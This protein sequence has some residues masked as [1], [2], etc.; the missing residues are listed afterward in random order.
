MYDGFPNSFRDFKGIGQWRLSHRLQQEGEASLPTRRS[1]SLEGVTRA[2]SRQLASEAALDLYVHRLQLIPTAIFPITI[3]SV[4]LNPV[5][6]GP[7]LLLLSWASRIRGIIEIK[8]SHN[9]GG[10][11]GEGISIILTKSFLKLNLLW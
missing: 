4:K 7:L 9:L 3:I 2:G 10:D 11:A 8:K 6:F 1:Q 5:H